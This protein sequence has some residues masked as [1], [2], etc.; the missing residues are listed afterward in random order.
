[1][2]RGPRD[3]IPDTKVEIIERRKAIPLSENEGVYV[4]DHNSGEVKLVRGPKT[5]LLGENESFWEKKMSPEIE[6]LL[7]APN[8][9]FVPL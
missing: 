1:M 7:G 2:I 3:L 9:G 8:Q 4:R 5:F 6:R